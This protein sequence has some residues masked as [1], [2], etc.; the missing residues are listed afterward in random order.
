VRLKLFAVSFIGCD[1]EISL[2]SAHL[3]H[4]S[5]KL[6]LISAF[7]LRQTIP[8]LL[9]QLKRNYLT[10]LHR[11]EHSTYQQDSLQERKRLGTMVMMMTTL[12]IMHKKDFFFKRLTSPYLC[13]KCVYVF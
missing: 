7:L 11:N 10:F 1:D 8:T 4:I 3:S 5:Q 6:I 12:S 9:S 13:T 2:S